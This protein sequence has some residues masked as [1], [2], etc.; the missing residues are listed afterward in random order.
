MEELCDGGI[1]RWRSY[2]ME[3]LCDILFLLY[4]IDYLGEMS[5]S[6]DREIDLQAS[7][8]KI[9]DMTTWHACSI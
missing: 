9:M 2:A 4:F 3:E 7:I 5:N 1:M 8:S 6:N